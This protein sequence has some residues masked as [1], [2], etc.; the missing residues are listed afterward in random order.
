MT[1]RRAGIAD[2]TDKI[3][4]PLFS[5]AQQFIGSGPSLY[6][7]TDRVD[8]VDLFAKRSSSA[9]DGAVFSGYACYAG[10][11]SDIGRLRPMDYP[12][13]LYFTTTLRLWQAIDENFAPHLQNFFIPFFRQKIRRCRKSRHLR[14]LFVIF[15]RKRNSICCR[16]CCSS[17]DVCCGCCCAPRPGSY[18]RI[19]AAA[20]P[21][22]GPAWNGHFYPP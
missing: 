18:C 19:C 11:Q 6:T 22:P 1:R 15:F 12:T 10:Q 4:L 3:L 2:L 21:L 16:S 17:P 20:P 13:S 7:N 5:A 9:S 8:N 14:I